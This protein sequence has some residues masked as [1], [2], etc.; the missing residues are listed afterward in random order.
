LSGLVRSRIRGIDGLVERLAVGFVERFEL[1]ALARGKPQ[2]A[3]TF[4]AA[5]AMTFAPSAGLDSAGFFG[6]LRD[7][8][9]RAGLGASSGA[10]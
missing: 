4:G 10:S 5:G 8:E 9:D 2:F 1:L 7:A 6:L 3:M